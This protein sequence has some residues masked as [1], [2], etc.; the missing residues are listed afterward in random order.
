MA[1]AHQRRERAATD[2]D[3]PSEDEMSQNGVDMSRFK[4]VLKRSALSLSLPAVAVV[5]VVV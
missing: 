4:S 2:S 5:N 1:E 3:P